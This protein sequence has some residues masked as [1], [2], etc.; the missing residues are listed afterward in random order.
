MSGG[1]CPE[2]PRQKMIGMM[3]LFLTAMLALNVS[4]ELL[5][6]FELV[7]KSIQ[8][9]TKTIQAKNQNLYRDL[10][11][12][13]ANNERAK[14][15]WER[16]KQIRAAADSLVGHLQDLKL[17]F[18]HTVDSKEATLDNYKGADNQDVAAQLMITEKGGGRS[19]VLKEKIDSYRKLLL[20]VVSPNDTTLRSAIELALTTKEPEGAIA[21]SWESEKFEHLPMSASL[22]LMSKLIGDVRN[23]EADV[24]KYLSGSVDAGT[25]KFTNVEAMIIPRS[26][27]VIRGS[28]YQAQ[29]LVTAVDSTQNPKY[30]VDGRLLTEVDSRG[31]GVLNLPA[32]S[33]G[34]KKFEVAIEVL[35]PEGEPL[36]LKNSSEY[37]V[38]DPMVVISPTKM[39]VF[40]EGVENPVMVSV[41][42]LTSSQLDIEVTNATRYKKGDE[43]YVKV[44]PGTAGLKAKVNV[45]AKI[46]GKTQRMD[47]LE[48][49]I[50]RLPA[51][52]AKVAGINEG[53]INKNRLLA[54]TGVFAEM[55][56]FDFA[57]EYVVTRFNVSAIKNGYNVDES[58]KS[59]RFTPAQTELIKGLSRGSKVFINDIKAVG[60]DKVTKSLGSITLTLD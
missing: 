5:K 45:I 21:R 22:A 2:T 46:D 10:Q 51:P 36:V 50:K 41:P 59:N 18:V 1:N 17:E 13:A 9:T 4:G 52:I 23:T 37:E 53:K 25:F 44:N 40:Y 38:V 33:S 30:F 55:E 19:K 57:L 7:D 34:K 11:N 6:A 27:V 29:L 60:P 31:I 3:Y 47:G 48:F 15:P 56:D 14:E 39:N 8:Q 26:Q 32:Q 20:S 43:Y 42:G 35:G 24:L 58:S 28:Q 54:E 12:D 16:A 49:R